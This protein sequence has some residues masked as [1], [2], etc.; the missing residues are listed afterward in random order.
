MQH[1]AWLLRLFGEGEEPEGAGSSR[2]QATRAANPGGIARWRNGPTR[3]ATSVDGANELAPHVLLD[4]DSAMTSGFE[5]WTSRL[6]S[7]VLLDEAL[8]DGQRWLTRPWPG[9]QQK[10]PDLPKQPDAGR[11]A[12]GRSQWL[13]GRRTRPAVERADRGLR[14]GTCRPR[15]AR[16]SALE[17]PA[18]KPT[19]RKK[20]TE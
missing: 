12:S 15:R 18:R 9:A 20:S 13:R 8:A 16:G 5:L 14:S 4:W 6:A 11:F 10:L 3:T 1:S 7:E 2:N 19:P 17:K